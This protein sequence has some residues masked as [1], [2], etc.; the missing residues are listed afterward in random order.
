MKGLC[1]MST[2]NTMLK[3]LRASLGEV[4]QESVQCGGSQQECERSKEELS[5]DERKQVAAL[6]SQR[7]P[8]GSR[9]KLKH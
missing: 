3:Y 1:G 6:E 9:R 5:R 7:G 4:R 2:L 8:R